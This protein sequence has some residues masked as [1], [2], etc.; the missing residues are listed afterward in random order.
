MA[1]IEDETEFSD[2]LAF[3]LAQWRNMRQQKRD[4]RAGNVNLP[5]CTDKEYIAQVKQEFGISSSD[6]NDDDLSA[7]AD[8]DAM[9]IEDDENN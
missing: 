7:A 3:V 4:V 6:N 1:D 9:E 2:M 5:V 8:G